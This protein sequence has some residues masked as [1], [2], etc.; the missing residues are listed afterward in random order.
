MNIANRLFYAIA[1]SIGFLIV[2]ICIAF[3]KLNN[4]VTLI[5]TLV[6]MVVAQILAFLILKG[7][8]RGRRI[9]F[10][11]VFLM[12]AL[13]MGISIILLALNSAFNPYV[14]HKALN[15]SELAISLLIFAGLF[16]LIITTVI[17]LF[18][19]RRR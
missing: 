3:F 9:N 7:N 5:L 4:N 16:P 1:I 2:H 8:F 13:T 10:M 6:A 17:W 12:L 14:E 11:D 15:L 19:L 18:I